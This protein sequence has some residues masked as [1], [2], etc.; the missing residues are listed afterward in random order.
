MALDRREPEMARLCASLS[1]Y[2]G[3]LLDR[4][5]DVALFLH[6]R[7]VGVE[8]LL[9][10]LMRDEDCAAYQVVLHAFADPET[11]EQEARATADGIL[12]VGSVCTLPFSVQGVRALFAA[13]ALAQGLGDVQVLPRHLALASF[14]HLPSE[15]AA[16][17]RAAGWIADNAGTATAAAEIDSGAPLFRS[18]ANDAKRNLSAAGR[19]AH[20]ARQA[21]ISAAQVLLA[22]LEIQPA[23]ESE[24]GLTRHRARAALRDLTADSTPLDPRPLRGDAGLRAFLARL[25]ASVTPGGAGSLELLATYHSPE[26]PE[27]AQLL[28]RNKVTRA[29]LERSADAFRDPEPE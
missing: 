21:S 12:V 28:T 19:A 2:G 24:L 5:G 1:P 15:A 13:R 29:L 27:L 25:G 23:L 8:H 6:A 10:A 11:I 18:F 7:E 22:A 9:C 20:Q 4:A 3:L 17:L 14:D 16:A 26:T